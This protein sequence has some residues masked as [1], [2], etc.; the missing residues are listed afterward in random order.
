[1]TN[2][3]LN[4]FVKPKKNNSSKTS[5]VKLKYKSI[6]IVVLVIILLI[7]SFFIFQRFRRKTI[8]L[9]AVN[10]MYTFQNYD[11]LYQ[12]NMG[13]LKEIT[14]PE[15]YKQLTATNVD[16]A[17][18]TYLKFQNTTVT[19]EPIK[20]TDS[21]IIYSLKTTAITPTRKFCFYYHTN[22]FGKIDEV[23]EAE[24]YGFYDINT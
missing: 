3:I 6:L 17:L 21:Y 24:L 11:S 18:T 1:M 22:L 16:R 7:S 2:N 10:D 19:V 20:V 5:K 12:N 9:E 14:T 8:G 13:K 23:Y 4:K 15:I